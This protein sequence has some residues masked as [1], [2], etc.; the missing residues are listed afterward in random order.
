MHPR[1][2][3]SVEQR[4]RAVAFFE[5]GFGDRWV[6]TKMGSSREAVKTLYQRWRIHGRG[7]LVKK[8]VQGTYSFEFKVSLVQ[9]FLAGEN[10]LTLSQEAGLSSPQQLKAWARIYRRDGVDGLKPKPRGRPRNQPV[11]EL[12]ELEQLRRENER[13]RAENAYLGKLQALR[14]QHRR[15]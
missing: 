6:A 14:Q 4:E 10:A 5:E 3:L 2:S 8:R 1:S 9:R 13:L 7:A 15:S 12:S 11:E